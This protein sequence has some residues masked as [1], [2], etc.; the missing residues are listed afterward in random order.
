VALAGEIPAGAEFPVPPGDRGPA[1]WEAEAHVAFGSN[2][3]PVHAFVESDDAPPAT[4]VAISRG[5][6]RWR[7]PAGAAG[8][9]VLR[10]V[11]PGV[12]AGEP[13]P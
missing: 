6:F 9:L 13:V 2:G 8:W 7:R 10:L 11:H 4:R 3:I 1:P 12:A 5:L